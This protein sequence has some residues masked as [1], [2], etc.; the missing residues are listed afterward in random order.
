MS[1]FHDWNEV[2][3]TSYA[4]CAHCDRVGVAKGYRSY[5]FHGDSYEDVEVWEVCDGE[6]IAKIL[7]EVD[8]ASRAM[9]KDLILE[10]HKHLKEASEWLKWVTG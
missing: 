9:E 4:V 10:V 5:G 6:Q 2:R 8:R 7:E 3:G 1:C